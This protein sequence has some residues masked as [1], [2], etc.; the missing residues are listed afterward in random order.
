MAVVTRYTELTGCRIPVQQAPMGSVSTAALAVAVAEAGGVGS[1]GVLGMSPAQV[2]KVLGGLAA[3]TSG[4]LAV[5]FLTSDIDP[6]AVA[7]AAGRVRIIDFFWTDPDPAL[8]EVAHRGGALACWQVGSRAEARAAAEAGCDL[9]AVQG[10]E[11]GGHVRGHSP[12]LPLLESVRGL[13]YDLPVLAA[14]GIGDARAFAAALAAGADGVRAGTRFVAAAESGAHPLYKQAVTEA[15]AGSTEI[16]GDFSVCPLCATSPRARVLTSCVGAL[17][18]VAGDTVGETTRGGQRVPV[19]RGHG[20][21]PGA[22]AT[23]HIDAMPMYAG[24]SAA[25]ITSVEPA[26][27]I[28]EAWSAAV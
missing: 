13:G 2:D 22:A 26:A 17:R 19:P 10:T 28:L 16:T 7:A 3:R 20:T 12:L 18:D 9:I 11:A 23:G 15:A 8:V 24:E 21:P 27:A 1:I 25:A 5:N 14:G 6:E 4:V